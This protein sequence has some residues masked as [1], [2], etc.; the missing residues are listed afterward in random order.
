MTNR[1]IAQLIPPLYRTEIL[2]KNHFHKAE[3]INEFDD[4]DVQMLWF[5]WGNL[6]EPENP[7]YHY[8]IVNG[9]IIIQGQCKKCLAEL[10]KKWEAI[11]PHL[12]ELE[13]EANMLKLIK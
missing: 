10:K 9:T 5:Y 11:M 13:Q 8:T 12:I 4:R 6:V 3:H 2:L 7:Q 1:E